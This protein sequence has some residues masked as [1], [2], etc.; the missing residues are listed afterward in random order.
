[1]PL[2]AGRKREWLSRRL[3]VSPQVTC[4]SESPLNCGV[5][6][7]EFR[8]LLVSR[9]QTNEILCL[10]GLFDVRKEGIEP[11]LPRAV[12]LRTVNNACAERKLR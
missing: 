5:L 1:M 12:T 9:A 10:F 2:Q 8:Q 4:Q 3:V 6:W 11:P 7:Q